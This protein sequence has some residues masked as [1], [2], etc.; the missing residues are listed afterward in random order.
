MSKID[1]EKVFEGLIE[2]VDLLSQVD[3]EKIRE[4]NEATSGKVQEV[5]N[6][7]QQIKEGKSDAKELLPYFVDRQISLILFYLLVI[8]HTGGGDWY[9]IKEKK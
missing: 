1:N 6:L 2:G 5:L 4:L 8:N 9:F 3:D 7:H